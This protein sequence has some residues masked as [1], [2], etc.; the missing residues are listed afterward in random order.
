MGIQGEVGQQLSYLAAAGVGTADFVLLLL[1]G[2]AFNHKE[3][4]RAFLHSLRN[5]RR[6]TA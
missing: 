6:R 2:Y 5:R 1:I 3:R 4:T